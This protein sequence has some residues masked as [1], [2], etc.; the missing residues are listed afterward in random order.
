MGRS[1]GRNSSGRGGQAGRGRGRSN[2]S[3][4][5]QSG[6]STKKKN[7]S[8]HIY[9]VGSAKQASDYVTITSYLINYI[10]RTYTKGE[11]VANAL[12]MLEEIDFQPLAP[13]LK[14][15]TN[16]DKTIMDREN[17]QFDKEFEVECMEY[18]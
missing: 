4:D 1:S 12:E 3:N 14:A 9:Y 7:L 15:S 5:K 2:R 17:C 10:R 8:D 11:D 13:V 16:S 18:N 6:S